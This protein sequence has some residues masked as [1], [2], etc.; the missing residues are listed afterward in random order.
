MAGKAWLYIAL[1]TN[2]IKNVP[3]EALG[4]A[5]SIPWQ[6]GQDTIRKCVNSLTQK[7]CA[8]AFR[9]G[10]DKYNISEPLIQ[11]MTTKHVLFT[12]PQAKL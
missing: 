9:C 2:T 12:L 10:I 1:V 3:T 8:V 4:G 5:A 11:S 7:C 6:F